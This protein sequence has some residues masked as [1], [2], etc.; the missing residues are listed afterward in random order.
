MTKGTYT[1]LW[2]EKDPNNAGSNSKQP[3]IVE[4]LFDG[5]PRFKQIRTQDELDKAIL[6][7]F[8]LV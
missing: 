6:V 5:K 4:H 1:P 7:S 8:A 2:G 3:K